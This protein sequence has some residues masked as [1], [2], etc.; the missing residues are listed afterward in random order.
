MKNEITM[1]QKIFIICVILWAS[2]GI[3][4][5]YIKAKESGYKA[6]G[7]SDRLLE[8][9]YACLFGPLIYLFYNDKS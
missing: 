4:G 8:I 2:I 7:G 3:M 6:Y 9:V 1:D 5:Y